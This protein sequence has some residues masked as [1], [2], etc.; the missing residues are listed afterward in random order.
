[1]IPYF[2][3]QSNLVEMLNINVYLSNILLLPSITLIYLIIY[4]IN[5]WNI[6]NYN[7]KFFYMDM[8][9]F[10]FITYTFAF[11][12][13]TIYHYFMFRNNNI[14]KLI[15]KLD[16]KI[17]AP[18][19]TVVVIILSILYCN[20]CLFDKNNNY[21]IIFILSVIF[22]LTGLSMYFCR[23]YLFLPEIKNNKDLIIY[24]INHVGFHYV[25]YTGILLISVLLYLHYEDIYKCIYIN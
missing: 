22:N 19:L 9:I 12:I 11:I 16:Y 25:T 2:I 20:T 3:R 10:V 13:S 18:L 21:W 17:T 15:G 8:W 14:F 6:D 4:E 1:M 5:N 7:C 23:R 24:L